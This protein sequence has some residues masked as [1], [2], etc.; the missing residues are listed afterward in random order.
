MAIAADTNALSHAIGATGTTQS[1]AVSLTTNLTNNIILAFAHMYDAGTGPGTKTF[2]V[3]GSTLGAFTFR[4]RVRTNA[5]FGQLIELHWILA[6]GALS[7]ETITATISGGANVNQVSLACFAINGANTTTPFDVNAA[8]PATVSTASG[9]AHTITFSTTAT[10]T[11]LVGLEGSSSTTPTTW[12]VPSAWTSV[13]S[14]SAVSISFKSMRL[15]VTSAQSS[16]SI[17]GQ[18]GTS[19]ILFMD[20]LQEAGGG[21]GGSF[22]PWWSNN[23]NLPVLGTGTF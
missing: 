1:R 21:G 10:N 2:T 17:T 18:G 7:A 14:N 12:G 16:Q 23:N 3:S 15:G 11:M 13:D 19:D 20:A 22:S 6:T 5:A 9:G 8:L 4:N